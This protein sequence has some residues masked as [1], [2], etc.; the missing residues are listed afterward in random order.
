MITL[1]L[2]HEFYS[3]LFFFNMIIILSIF[4]ILVKLSYNYRTATC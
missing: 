2:I 3:L 1:I 4:L